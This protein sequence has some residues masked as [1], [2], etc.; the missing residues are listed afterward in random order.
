MKVDQSIFSISILYE[1]GARWYGCGRFEILLGCDEHL[2]ACCLC[3]VHP[4]ISPA[5]QDVHHKTIVIVHL[6]TYF[7]HVNCGWSCRS[8]LPTYPDLAGKVALI[9]GTSQVGLREGP[10]WGNGLATARFNVRNGVQ[11]FR[12]DL[13]LAAAERT[14]KRLVE[15]TPRAVIDVIA[16]DGIKPYGVRHSS[17]TL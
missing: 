6:L 3:A 10:F 9:T 16:A 2:Q 7:R 14:K 17:R 15:N 8:C 1:N 13:H 12:C 11:I 5:S 4:V